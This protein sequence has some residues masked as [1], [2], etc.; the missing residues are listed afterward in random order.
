MRLHQQKSEHANMINV[1]RKIAG[2]SV[3]IIL[4]LVREK[5]RGKEK[6]SDY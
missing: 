6:K 3:G 2:T 4:V 5:Q 1:N